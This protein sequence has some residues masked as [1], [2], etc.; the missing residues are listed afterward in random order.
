M[1]LLLLPEAGAPVVTASVP[2]ASAPASALPRRAQ[3]SGS[4]PL[5]AGCNCQGQQQLCDRSSAGACRGFHWTDVAGSPAR[6]DGHTLF[7]RLRDDPEH[8]CDW[9]QVEHGE[10]QDILVH[11]VGSRHT[12]NQKGAPAA[13]WSA[14]L[15]CVFATLKMVS[16][17]RLSG[18]QRW[19]RAVAG[20]GC[21]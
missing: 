20:R 2:E 9:L 17:R 5:P 18:L 13:C 6:A 14:F 15:L 8:R 11:H 4:E 21:V 10:S 1:R 12:Q 3:L 19:D 16:R 7:L